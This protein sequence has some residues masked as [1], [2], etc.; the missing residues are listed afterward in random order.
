MA[1]DTQGARDTGPSRLPELRFQNPPLPRQPGEPDD[2]AWGQGTGSQRAVNQSENEVIF[3]KQ[4]TFLFV[5]VRGLREIGYGNG[6][7]V[8]DRK[9]HSLG[10]I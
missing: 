1:A 10:R 5:C 3:Y 6:K 7:K 4:M 2:L 8:G 9:Q